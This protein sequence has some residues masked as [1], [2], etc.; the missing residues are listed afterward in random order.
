MRFP[1]RRPRPGHQTRP[2]LTQ[3]RPIC[4]RMTH[5]PAWP[6]SVRAG[7]P[8]WR[9]ITALAY[10]RERKVSRN[11]VHNPLLPGCV[12]KHFSIRNKS[13]LPGYSRRCVIRSVDLGL[14]PTYM[15][16]SVWRG[17]PRARPR[18]GRF[19]VD[20]QDAQQRKDRIM[21]TKRVSVMED[22]PDGCC[23]GH[24]RHGLAGFG[25]V[26]G[27]ASRRRKRYL[28]ANGPSRRLTRVIL[29]T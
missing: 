19:R 13:C 29:T 11:L 20:F 16:G 21:T 3:T 18:G 23:Y 10:R 4:Q 14:S 25:W 6:L 5:H 2:G 17:T 28:L 22:V 12:K 26:S 9:V 15:A 8:V 24:S 7:R 1:R 27:C